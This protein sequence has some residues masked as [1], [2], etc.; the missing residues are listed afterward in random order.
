MPTRVSEGA[1]EAFAAGLEGQDG[2]AALLRHL[3]QTMQR[4]EVLP[5]L[6]SAMQQRAGTDNRLP[7]LGAMLAEIGGAAAVPGA[8]A[9]LA[10]AAHYASCEWVG[11][12]GVGG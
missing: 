7:A 10:T 4:P 12:G 3:E 11:W 8:L 5:L 9:M 6:E 2:G 1:P